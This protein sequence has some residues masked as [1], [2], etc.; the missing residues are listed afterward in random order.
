MSDSTIDFGIRIASPL[1][2]EFP[3]CPAFSMLG[4]EE[5]D[6]SVGWVSVG[7]FRIGR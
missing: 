7:T 2:P 4:I 6:K 3:Y 5:L 1:G